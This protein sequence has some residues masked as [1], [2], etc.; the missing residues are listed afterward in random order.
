[1]LILSDC[2]MTL[3]SGSDDGHINHALVEELRRAVNDGAELWL[4]SGGGEAH[5]R[6]CALELGLPVTGFFS[7]PD[8][9]PMTA[10]AAVDVL[11]RLPDVQYDDDL[12]EEIPGVK[13][14]LVRF[15]PRSSRLRSLGVP[16]G[17]L[18]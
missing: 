14:H 5:A 1:M 15:M 10:S 17:R 3:W 2:A 8:N 11:G 12:G 4:W 7:K 9:W 18:T 6:R 16:L 13:F